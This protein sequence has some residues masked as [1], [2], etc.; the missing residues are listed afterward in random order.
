MS[1]SASLANIGPAPTIALE[2]EKNVVAFVSD[3]ESATALRQGL[4]PHEGSVN[5]TIGNIRHAIRHLER[6]SV[7]GMLIVDVE[8]IEHPEGVLDDLARVCPPDTQVVVVGDNTEI[9]F[10]RRL[11]GDLGVTEYL[12]KP[13]TRESVQQLFSQYLSGGRV[14]L[15]A[16]RGGK[17]VVVC[18]ARGGVGSTTIAVA[19]AH[20]LSR[21]TKGHVSLLDL[22]L[23]NGS[24]AVM[25]GGRPG[26]GLR[27]ALEDPTRADALFLER[28]AFDVNERLR[29][30]AAEEGFE[31]TP[32]LN[33]AGVVRVLEL[34]RQK[35]NYVVVDLPV[36]PPRPMVRVFAVARQVVVVLKPDVTG[37]RD[38][39]AVRRL[40]IAATGSDRVITV[41]NRSNEPG[42]LSPAL[43]REGLGTKPDATIPDLGKGMVQALNLGVPAVKRVPALRKYLAPILREVAGIRPN[44]ARSLFSRMFAR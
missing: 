5:V 26:P 18:G 6:T 17:V 13:L 33:E 21:V 30:V 31:I 25:M 27:I 3:E 11:V 34:L 7:S 20:E 16:T 9:R 40:V 22:H 39:K 38:A 1:S 2:G 29:L 28:T 36:P 23:Q 42:A 8:G 14:A 15:P 44:G 19:L 35:S 37:L 12:P 32:E 10:Y 41:V 24:T 43:I 4:A